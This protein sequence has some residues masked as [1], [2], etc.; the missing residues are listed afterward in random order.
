MFFLKNG[1]IPASFLFIFVLFSLHFQ[2][3]LKKHRWCAWDSNPE[4]QDG[5]HRRNHGA[6]SLIRL[7]Q[8][9][10]KDY[11]DL[12]LTILHISERANL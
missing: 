6:G 12:M 9:S 10:E 1:Q 5:R 4:P 2:N 7:F 8:S 11:Q 3:K